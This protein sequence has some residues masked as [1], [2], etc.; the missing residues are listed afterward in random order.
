[1]IAQDYWSEL[2]RLAGL[3]TE[4]DALPGHLFAAAEQL[5]RFFIQLSGMDDADH[6]ARTNVLLPQ[7]KAIGSIWAAHCIRDYRRTNVFLRGTLQAIRAAG[8]RFPGQPIHVLYA[9]CGP[10][11]TLALPLIP[12]LD[13][14]P[15]VFTC[16]D[17]SPGSLGYLRKIVTA[18]HLTPWIHDIVLA[19]ATE[20]RVNPAMPVHVLVGEMMM[21]G[22][23]REPQV[24]AMLHLAPQLAPGG[25]LIPQCITVQAG[26]LHP[27][28]NQARMM[29]P[30]GPD[31]EVY[32]LLPPAFEWSLATIA[33]RAD[34]VDPDIF[35]EMEVLLPPDRDP[36]F[37][38]LALFTRIQV[39]ESERLECWESVLT[40]P[41]PLL[42]LGVDPSIRKIGLRYQLGSLPGFAWRVID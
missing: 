23:V 15:V 26:L 4:P 13:G 18:L 20:Y 3:L 14:Q 11:A 22:L 16:L 5:Y 36:Q 7:G 27:T 21:N 39:F 19:D 34:Q 33:A 35:P 42:Q 29:R 24:A 37:S 40:Y 28:R 6:S 1:M 12:L 10:F 38:E 30:E 32:H 17:I 41:L 9:G 31:G 2:K 25:L 8:R